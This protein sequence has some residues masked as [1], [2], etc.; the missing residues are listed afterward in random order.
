VMTKYL[1]SERED[2]FHL[3]LDTM[4]AFIS[5][6]ISRAFVIRHDYGL[7]EYTVYVYKESLFPDQHR[8]AEQP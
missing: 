6:Q 5:R 7:F 2:L 4:A 3:P 8:I 1:D